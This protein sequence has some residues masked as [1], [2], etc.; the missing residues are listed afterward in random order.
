MVNSI[1]HADPQRTVQ[2]GAVDREVLWTGGRSW[3]CAGWEL[4]AL[5]GAIEGRRIGT[6][7]ADGTDRFNR[8]GRP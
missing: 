2:T 8:E 4:A 1:L 5:Y 7:G 6:V 3:V